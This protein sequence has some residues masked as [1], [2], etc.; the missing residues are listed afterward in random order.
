[1]VEEDLSCPP[2]AVL[3]AIQAIQAIQAMT[4]AT[5]TSLATCSPYA[6]VAQF[7][8]LER[9]AFLRLGKRCPLS[10]EEVSSKGRET[11]KA[12]APVRHL[13]A[14]IASRGRLVGPRLL[15]SSSL[16]LLLDDVSCSRDTLLPLAQIGQ[17][18]YRVLSR[19]SVAIITVGWLTE[20]QPAGTDFALREFTKLTKTHAAVS[21]PTTAS[22][23]TGH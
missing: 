8:F 22:D 11:A 12:E 13:D 19:H 15:L 14:H 9:P 18:T 1:M 10:A 3:P 2:A 7:S 17:S 5:E 23:D 20:H 16:R 21:V 4:M 6:S